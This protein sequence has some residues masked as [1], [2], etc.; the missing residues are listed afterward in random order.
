MKHHPAVVFLFRFRNIVLAV[1]L[2]PPP[3]NILAAIVFPIPLPI[4][5]YIID[6]RRLCSDSVLN[7][8]P[9]AVFRF[10]FRIRYVSRGCVPIAL[11]SRR[12]CFVPV[13]ERSPYSKVCESI[14]NISPAAA[15]RYCFRICTR[16][17][18]F[19]PVSEHLFPVYAF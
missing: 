13:S 9:S 1:V 6:V 17:L 16:R 11:Y 5:I 8:Y 3:P 14:P 2:H 12:L 4:Y 19:D 7:A 15:F 18:C 10:R